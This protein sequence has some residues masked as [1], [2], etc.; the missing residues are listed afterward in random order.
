MN[1]LKY[2]IVFNLKIK[3]N[4]LIFISL[5]VFLVTILIRI[6]NSLVGLQVSSKTLIF[7]VIEI[8]LRL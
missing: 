8:N 2:L 1:V 4:Y 3:Q 7:D 5:G 6:F